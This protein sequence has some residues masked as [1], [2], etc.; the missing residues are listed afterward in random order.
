VR[1]VEAAGQNFSLRMAVVPNEELVRIAFSNAG[2][3]FVPEAVA[4]AKLEIQHRGID[5]HASS[6]ILEQIRNDPEALE[7]RRLQRLGIAGK[8]LSFVGGMCLGIPVF[9]I[10]AI[11]KMGYRRK[12]KDAIK[13]TLFGLSFSLIVSIIVARF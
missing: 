13:W 7:N 1:R 11:F 10:W 4:A 3:G 2:D 5:E 6:Q 12:G 8:A 9:F